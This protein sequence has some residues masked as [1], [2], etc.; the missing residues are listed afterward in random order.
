ML[1]KIALVYES[2]SAKAQFPNTF[3]SIH[4]HDCVYMQVFLFAKCPLISLVI[5]VPLLIGKEENFS[6]VKYLC[7]P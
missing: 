4:K 2:T 7:I 3:F 1:R 6:S 5:T